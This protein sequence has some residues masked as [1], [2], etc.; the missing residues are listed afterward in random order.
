MTTGSSSLV[1]K[2]LVFPPKYLNLVVDPANLA[3]SAGHSSKLV[4]PNFCAFSQ[5]TLWVHQC[6]VVFFL[7]CEQFPHVICFRQA[8]LLLHTQGSWKFPPTSTQQLLKNG[9]MSQPAE[10]SDLAKWS[11][12]P[13]F[14]TYTLVMLF[15]MASLLMTC[16][17]PCFARVIQLTSYAES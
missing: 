8:V 7:S 13:S 4:G 3:C 17:C 10:H 16:P 15:S 1:K 9:Q 6:E 5:C 12:S 2:F 14:I 11:P